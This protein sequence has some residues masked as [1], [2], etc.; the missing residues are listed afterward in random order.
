[1]TRDLRECVRLLREMFGGGSSHRGPE[2]GLVFS[3]STAYNRSDVQTASAN[4]RRRIRMRWETGRGNSD[5]EK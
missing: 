2:V 1:V 5:S 3:L 4:R